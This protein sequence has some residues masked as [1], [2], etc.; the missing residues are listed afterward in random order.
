MSK[1]ISINEMRKIKG[2]QKVKP[3][4][5]KLTSINGIEYHS[6][7][8]RGLAVVFVTDFP[9]KGVKYEI[10]EKVG[11]GYKLIESGKTGFQHLDSTNKYQM[12][13]ALRQGSGAEKPRYVPKMSDSDFRNAKAQQI[14][15]TRQANLNFHSFDHE[16]T[17]IGHNSGKANVDQYD[18]KGLRKIWSARNEAFRAKFARV[19]YDGRNCANVEIQF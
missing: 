7:S 5:V 11:N 1:V 18:L 3:F 2:F 17:W 13:V 19:L 14:K 16:R 6:F 4:T 10:T 9:V 15:F 12:E 8:S